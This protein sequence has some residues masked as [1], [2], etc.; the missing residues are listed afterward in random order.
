[1]SSTSN[2]VSRK[3][4][5]SFTSTPETSALGSSSTQATS[6]RL[7]KKLKDAR[8]SSINT[9]SG[10]AQ[11]QCVAT[12]PSASS[13]VTSP[14]ADGVHPIFT[15]NLERRADGKEN[16]PQGTARPGP[17][18]AAG[19]LPFVNG[20]V[21]QRTQ[22]DATPTISAASNCPTPHLEPQPSVRID[23]LAMMFKMME[24]FEQKLDT[25]V[26]IQ[27]ALRTDMNRT[28]NRLDTISNSVDLVV[29]SAEDTRLHVMDSH[30]T[31][32]AIRQQ[33]F[34]LQANTIITQDRFNV[35]DWS[36]SVV[37]RDV[38]SL[39]TLASDIHS[40]ATATRT[41][42]THVAHEVAAVIGSI[43][44]AQN[45]ID[46]RISESAKSVQS[47]LLR[48]ERHLIGV[49]NT[50]NGI[51]EDIRTLQ[52]GINDRDNVVDEILKK[53]TEQAEMVDEIHYVTHYK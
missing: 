7:F 30:G 3:R 35:L 6:T 22:N 52:R 16:D 25:V 20:P 26:D 45:E 21:T 11:K 48:A 37:A 5:A 4:P 51:V 53:V 46:L 33:V 36:L 8:A 12:K 42:V 14:V 2:V 28:I 18:I 44:Q 9:K 43:D 15:S 50:C 41:D 27:R 13:T 47:H 29:E 39:R 24:R 34:N 49:P 19:F 23:T 10:L 1:M 40:I 32:N 31:S 17:P 38:K